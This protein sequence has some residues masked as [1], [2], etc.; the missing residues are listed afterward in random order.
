MI[1]QKNVRNHLLVG[2][3]FIVNMTINGQEIEFNQVIFSSPEVQIDSNDNSIKNIAD[4]WKL[5]LSNYNNENYKNKLWNKVEREQGFTDIVESAQWMKADPFTKF[6]IVDIRKVDKDFFKTQIMFSQENP[7]MIFSIFNIYAKKEAPG[8]SL[9]NNFFFSKFKFKDYKLENIHYYYPENYS[10][11]IE[12][13]Q[14]TVH[15]YNSIAALYNIDSKKELTYIIGNTLHEAYYLIG[16]DYLAAT[17]ESPLAGRCLRNQ[18]MIIACKEDHLH[19]MVHSLFPK[20]P[21]LF[22]EGIATYY[23][24]GNGKDY[25]TYVN[26]LKMEILRKPYID[27]SNIESLDNS[28][29]NGQINNFYGIGAI[30]ID[31][32]LKHGGP[33]KI[34]EL[35]QSNVSDS[36]NDQTAIFAEKLGVKMEEFDSFLRKL[37]L[38]YDAS[39]LNLPHPD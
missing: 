28:L 12:K 5:Y 19:E 11:N 7:P 14:S 21:A 10:F 15:A 9:F 31:Y 27:L 22:G 24:G 17:P 37:I 16:F 4:F 26:Y 23:G 35:L 25:A 2:L 18:N 6:T 1:F 39:N 32:A 34:L 36:L 30:L 29:N 33:K 8:Y 20:G 38:S 13:A 3:F